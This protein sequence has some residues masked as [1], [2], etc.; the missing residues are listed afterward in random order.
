M[1]NGKREV[2]MSGEQK[3]TVVVAAVVPYG[4]RVF[5][6]RKRKSNNPEIVGRWECPGGKVNFGEDFIDALKREVREELSLEVLVGRPL[7]SQINTY[8]DGVDYLVL[9]Y[10]CTLRGAP[11]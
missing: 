6:Q 2:S 11:L 8:S 5:I 1:Q 7:H 9:F 10:H 3:A 4:G